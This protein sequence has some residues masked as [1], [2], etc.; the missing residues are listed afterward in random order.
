MNVLLP[1][2]EKKS[3]ELSRRMHRAGIREAD[4]TEE[5]VKGAGPGGQKINKSSI[6][7][8]LTHRPSGIQVRCQEGRSQAMNR[9]YAR[10]LLTEKIEERLFR[11][12]SAKRQ[13]MEKIRRQKR[14][15]SKRA[16]DKML[17]GKRHQS[18]KKGMRRKPGMDS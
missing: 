5:F 8:L 18:E 16:K 17:A 7:V 13:A 4:L 6:A 14:K 2:S 12:K 3:E 9:F 11:E 10:R 1:V 15:R